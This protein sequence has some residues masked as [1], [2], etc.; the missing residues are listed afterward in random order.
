MTSSIE[1]EQETD[2]RWLAAVPR[3]PGVLTY[4]LTRTDAVA[5][6]QVPALRVLADRLEHGE[7]G[8]EY[9]NLTFQG[10]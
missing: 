4:G 8:P 6:V 3:L 1:I 9:L 10:A 5:K 7:A 2:G